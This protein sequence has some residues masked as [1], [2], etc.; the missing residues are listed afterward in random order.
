MRITPELIKEAQDWVDGINKHFKI[1]RK[2]I[3]RK[4][5]SSKLWGAVTTIPEDNSADIIINLLPDSR[6]PKADLFLL[7]YHE[8]IHA[9]LWP[10]TRKNVIGGILDKEEEKIVLSMTSIMSKI[11]ARNYAKTSRAGG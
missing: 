11:L 8:M 4:G 9:L 7:M 10:L 5:K 1:K 6:H 2:I 3:V